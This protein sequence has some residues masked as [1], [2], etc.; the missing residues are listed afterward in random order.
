MD[1]FTPTQEPCQASEKSRSRIGR[2]LV[3]WRA[4]KIDEMIRQ[5]VEFFVDFSSEC[6]F[7]P[8]N[9]TQAIFY[10]E[11]GLFGR[12]FVKGELRVNLVLSFM[13]VWVR[14]ERSE[15]LPNR[16]RRF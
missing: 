16:E 10:C 12:F 9:G 14:H 2:N 8:L 6:L 15:P 4:S 7:Y 1:C 11:H 13:C 3:I 5:S